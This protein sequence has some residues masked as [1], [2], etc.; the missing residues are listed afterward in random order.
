VLPEQARTAL[1]QQAQQDRLESAGQPCYELP[2]VNGGIDLAGLYRLAA[3]LR[4]Q[5]FA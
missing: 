1:G 3:V 2:W 4:E 5:R